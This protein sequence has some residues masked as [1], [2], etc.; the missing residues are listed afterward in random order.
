MSFDSDCRSGASP[1]ENPLRG[2]KRHETVDMWHLTRVSY[3][4]SSSSSPSP[5]ILV[6]IIVVIIITIIIIFLV[7]SLLLSFRPRC[8]LVFLSMCGCR[9][10]FWSKTFF[11]LSV[12]LLEQF[13]N[14]CSILLFNVLGTLPGQ[15]FLDTLLDTCLSEPCLGTCSWEPCLG[16]CSWEP[17]LRNLLLGA[18]PDNLFLETFSWEPV[19][20]NFAC[21]LQ[22][23]SLGPC[24]G[25]CFS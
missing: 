9:I 2:Q 13:F 8:R 17:I 12:P 18:L 3:H 5:F 25:T 1:G 16:T 7:S 19:L 6:I 11:N 10:I 21:L 24:S 14:L 22:T 4:S 20:G 23:C 15:L